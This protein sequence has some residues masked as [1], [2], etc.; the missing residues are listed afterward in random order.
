MT[1]LE[2][3]VQE[4]Q[5]AQCPVDHAVY[6]RRKTVRTVEQKIPALECDAEGAWQV[7]GFEEARAILRS[8]DTRQAGFN[9]DMIN[10][11]N[12]IRKQ[13]ILYLEGKVHHE[14]RKQTARFFAPKVVSSNYREVMETLV[15]QLLK[16]ARRKKRFDLDVLSFKLAVRVAAEVVGLT[17]STLPGMGQRLEAFF[18]Q[19][20]QHIGLFKF[21]HQTKVRTRMASFFF[22]DVQPAIRARKRK[23]RED[24]ISH[25]ISQNYTPA[26]IMTECVTYGAAGM[27]TTREF[28]TVAAWHFLEHPALKERYLVA[29]ERERYA[30]LHEILRLEP[31]VGHL[32]RR[33]TADIQVNSEGTTYTIPQG[34]KIDISVYAANLD[35]RVLGEQTELVCPE[36]PLHGDRV[37]QEMMAFGDGYHRCPGAYIAIQETDI[38]LTR[39]LALDGL[40][41]EKRPDL[42]WND[43]V[44]GYELRGF[45]LRVN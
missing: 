4:K 18:V 32:Y 5:P 21:L 19:P 6:S 26:E 35:E 44:T 34:A 25:L 23:T 27:A 13:P 8:T 39:L 1:D 45:T 33:A 41:I 38:L 29:S 24:V 7:R 12:I 16:E 14:Q 31:V 11:V 36:R 17:S 37:P 3:S 42:Q 28:I 2:G 40:H 22:L 10:R 43:L 15:G 30:I 20:G 9:A